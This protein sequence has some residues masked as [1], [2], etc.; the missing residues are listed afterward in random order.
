MFR[1]LFL[2]NTFSVALAGTI[3]WDGRFN[4]MT[5]ST[6]LDDWSWSDQTGPY[7][8]Y[9]VRLKNLLVGD[10][11]MVIARYRE[12]AFICQPGLDI[13]ESCGHRQ[14]SGC[15]NDSRHYVLLGWAD[16]ETYWA[17]ST[18]YS[19]YWL[20]ISLL[21]LL[22]HAIWHERTKRVPWAPDCFLRES[23]HRNEGR[24][25]QRRVSN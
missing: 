17:H 12:R 19:C 21:S 1:S 20:W 25:D 13:Q 2:L 14:Y 22:N 11:L 8:Y 15:E 24:M 23:F 16:H 9:I 7:Q 18:N 5:S 10:L 4:D 6:E 3:L